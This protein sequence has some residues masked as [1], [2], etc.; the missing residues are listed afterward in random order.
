MF[1]IPMQDLPAYTE[2]I[3]FEDTVYTLKFVWNSR[4]AYWTIDFY[5]IDENPLVIGIK[6][7]LNYELISRFV[8]RGI[9]KGF[10]YAI[11]VSN[12]LEKIG[13]YDFINGRLSLIYVTEVEL[14]TV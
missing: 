9:P 10:L 14:A 3:V 12:N 5:D 7:V 13:R 8:D 1:K 2:Q 4:G 6:I 11:D